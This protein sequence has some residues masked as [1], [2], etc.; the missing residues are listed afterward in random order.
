MPRRRRA[1][2][3]CSISA[4][5][6]DPAPAVT[7]DTRDHGRDSSRTILGTPAHYMSPEQA[8]SGRL[9]RH[10]VPTDSRRH[11]G[12]WHAAVLPKN[13]G[14]ILVTALPVARSGRLHARRRWCCRAPRLWRTRA[15]SPARAGTYPR[16][17]RRD[18]Q[19]IVFLSQ[20]KGLGLVRAS[21]RRRHRQV[22]PAGAAVRRRS[23][24]RCQRH[25]RARGVARRVPFDF[26]S[27]RPSHSPARTSIH[28]RMGWLKV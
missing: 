9:P 24:R 18:R 4:S 15:S 12:R 8:R 16:R 19:G 6:R 22:Q 14:G 10:Q 21:W 3:S 11:V 13:T 17:W 2:S 25:Q 1:G 23:L 5:R 7:T 20:L 26:L 28:V 27:R